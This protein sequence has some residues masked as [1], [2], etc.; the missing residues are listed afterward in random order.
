MMLDLKKAIS[1]LI[2]Y[3]DVVSVSEVV[4]QLLSSSEKCDKNYYSHSYL[5]SLFEVDANAG[6]EFHDLQ[7]ILRL[8]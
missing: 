1:M 5:H 7:V 4:R 3:R 2:Q 8:I 6:K